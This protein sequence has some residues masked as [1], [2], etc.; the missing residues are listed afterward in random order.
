MDDYLYLIHVLICAIISCKNLVKIYNILKTELS[1]PDPI[2]IIINHDQSGPYE[3]YLT[4]HTASIVPEVV[5]IYYNIKSIIYIIH[6]INVYILHI[7]VYNIY[8]TIDTW[9]VNELYPAV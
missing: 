9:M 7:L 8:D 1:V 2:Y 3:D 5:T 4:P 6:C